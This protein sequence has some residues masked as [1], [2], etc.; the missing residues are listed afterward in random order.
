MHAKSQLQAEKVLLCPKTW[1]RLS[2]SGSAVEECPPCSTLAPLKVWCI[3]NINEAG[4]LAK[5]V[6]LNTVQRKIETDYQHI[7]QREVFPHQPTQNLGS[8][9][10][11][12]DQDPLPVMLKR[13]LFVLST[14]RPCAKT[15]L[16]PR[17]VWKL[18]CLT[19]ASGS[20][21]WFWGNPPGFHLKEFKWKK[22][23]WKWIIHCVFEVRSWIDQSISPKRM[24][25]WRQMTLKRWGTYGANIATQFFGQVSFWYISKRHV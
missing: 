8:D 21:S 3:E 22:G 11:L 15:S 25:R 13:S 18:V 1:S 2:R 16:E 6:G 19:F 20:S 5:W 9:V 23:C 14:K 17:G 4:N 10:L 12:F 24:R 7:S